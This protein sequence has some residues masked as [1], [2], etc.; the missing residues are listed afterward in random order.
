MGCG[1]SVISFLLCGVGVF[2]I[3]CILPQMIS[4]ASWKDMAR[5][6]KLT[7]PQISHG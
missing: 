5:G 3:H 2:E 6:A 7:S 1:V 4:L